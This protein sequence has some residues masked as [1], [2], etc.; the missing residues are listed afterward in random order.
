VIF[1]SASNALRK[2]P[3]Y[4]RTPALIDQVI[5][6][7]LDLPFPRRSLFF[8]GEE[9]MNRT[10]FSK[11]A[12]AITTLAAALLSFVWPGAIGTA[13]AADTSPW[14]YYRSGYGAWGW[15]SRGW[16]W[17]SGPYAGYVGTDW[18]YR[19][20]AYP[21]SDPNAGYRHVGTGYYPRYVPLAASVYY[22]Y[23]WNG[24]YRWYG[25]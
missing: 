22:S 15:D 4:V 13:A 6:D 12:I 24:G 23:P 19:G 18:G 3:Q 7:S 14:G 17:D 16:G 11:V 2:Q 1:L 20:G 5:L 21:Y 9:A 25:F 10:R 8:V